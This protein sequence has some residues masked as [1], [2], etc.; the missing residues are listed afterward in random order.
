MWCASEGR[1]LAVE[2]QAA[3]GTCGRQ[4]LPDLGVSNVLQS[5]LHR[6]MWP[7]SQSSPI[8]PSPLLIGKRSFLC[9]R[10]HR[11]SPSL[12]EQ[13]PSEPR[14]PGTLPGPPG[15]A[16]T[17]RGPENLKSKTEECEGTRGRE[18]GKN[19]LKGNQVGTKAPTSEK[20]K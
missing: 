9:P 16:D 1:A 5:F 17:H 10:D 8:Q 12:Q 13:T 18:D 11:P 6:S 7:R 4:F 19:N 20:Q 3:A 2:T 14:A 15:L